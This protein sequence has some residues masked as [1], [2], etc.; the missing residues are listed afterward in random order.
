MGNPFPAFYDGLRT[1]ITVAW[2]EMAGKAHPIYRESQVRRVAWRKLIE[3]QRLGSPWVVISTSDVP[4]ATNWGLYN[5]VF[6]P[7]VEIFYITEAVEGEKDMAAYIEKQLFALLDVLYFWGAGFTFASEISVDTGSRNPAQAVFLNENMP[8]FAGSVAFDAR[9]MDSESPVLFFHPRQ[10]SVC[11]LAPYAIT[12]SGS[13][14]SADVNMAGAWDLLKRVDA[15]AYEPTRTM[16]DFAPED[17][18][19]ADY[20]SGGK[21]D[22]TLAI[23][24]ID[25]QGRSSLLMDIWHAKPPALRFAL[26]AKNLD[27][28]DGKWLV[29]VATPAKLKNGVVYG[30]NATFLTLRPT[31]NQLPQW[32][33]TPTI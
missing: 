7:R 3:E 29:A 27:G 11:Q 9:V 22:F 26:R 6:S 14:A 30:K 23:G 17:G 12:V 13:G 19:I 16:I 31:W 2:P 4:Q 28:T 24:T 18:L 33:D 10:L 21:D 25:E 8:L 1:A 20:R 32:T 15:I 5:V